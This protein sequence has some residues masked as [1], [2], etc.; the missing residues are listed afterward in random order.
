MASDPLINLLVRCNHDLDA[1]HYKLDKEFRSLYPDNAN[2]IRLVS[3]IK[4]IRDD[5]SIV[6]DQCQELLSAKQDLIDKARTTLVGNR[7]LLHR[8]QASVAILPGDA[9]DPAY[10]NFKEV[11]DE[12]TA[13]VQS[14]AGN[15]TEHS[16]SNDI[17]K[18][19]F[20]AKVGG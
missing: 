6:K 13:Q 1:I 2:P 20:S 7:N 19:L 16:S 12:W 4:K 18:L 9:E 15:K 3:R 5:L 11:I 8:I 14:R 17:N 10:D